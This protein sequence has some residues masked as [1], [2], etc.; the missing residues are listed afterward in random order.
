MNFTWQASA[1][2]N[3]YEHRFPVA[4]D[5]RITYKGRAMDRPADG[6]RNPAQ[7]FFPSA[8]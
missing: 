2:G 1:T 4:T 8:V 3:E 5:N 7:N 6:H